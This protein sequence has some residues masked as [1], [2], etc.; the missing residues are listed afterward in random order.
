[1]FAVVVWC[2]HSQLF[3]PCRSRSSACSSAPP[4]EQIPTHSPLPG[5][6]FCSENLSILYIYSQS[7]VLL[8]CCLSKASPLLISFSASVFCTYLESIA[9]SVMLPRSQCSA[10]S[11]RERQTETQTRFAAHSYSLSQEQYC[12]EVFCS[13]ITEFVAVW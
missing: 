10:A 4:V 7:K 6:V 3:S 12:W 13:V 1:M 8:K 9:A 11:M 2:S 5:Q